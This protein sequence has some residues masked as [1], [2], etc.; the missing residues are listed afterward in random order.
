MLVAS[1]NSDLRTV[2]T[3]SRNLAAPPGGR[4]VRPK[5]TLSAHK[6]TSLARAH[7]Q[8]LLRMPATYASSNP[9]ACMRSRLRCL[10]AQSC[11][12]ALNVWACVRAREADLRTLKVISGRTGLPAG[13]PNSATLSQVFVGRSFRR[14]QTRLHSRRRQGTLLKPIAAAQI[15]GFRNS[16]N[17]AFKRRDK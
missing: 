8:T 11:L 14:K 10:R 13:L 5:I 7:A 4:P 12:C 9:R 1:E 3:I 15:S 16:G 6:S 2:G 17:V